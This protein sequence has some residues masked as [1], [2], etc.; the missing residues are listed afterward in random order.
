M[1]RF[2]S[3]VIFFFLLFCCFI[4][5]GTGLAGE[6]IR[7]GQYSCYDEKG[8]FIDHNGTGQD[9]DFQ[10]GRI[11]PLPR[12][13]DNGDGT[14]SDF[15]TGLMWLQDGACLGRLTWQGALE[16][17]GEESGEDTT[18]CAGY[19][20]YDDWTLPEIGQLENLFNAEENSPARW[21]NR[22]R[23]KNIRPEMYWSRTTGLNPY[24]AWVFDFGTGEVVN[25]SKVESRH[26]LLVRKPVAIG[27]KKDIES[28]KPLSL[29]RNISDLITFKSEMTGGD[30]SSVEIASQ[31][32]IR[33]I[34]NND[35]T[36]TDTATGLMWLRNAGCLGKT[37]WQ[38][39]F[40]RIDLLNRQPGE[41]LCSDLS[42]RYTDWALPNRNEFRSL[43]DHSTD[44]PALPA[45][46]FTDLRTYYWTSTTSAENPSKAYGIYLGSGE[47]RAA[48][49][50]EQRLIWA[51]RPVGGRV[52]RLRIE[53][54]QQDPLA[55]RDTRYLLQTIGA[56]VPIG[57]PAIRFTDNN[58]GTLTDNVTGLMW[59]MDA[60]CFQPEKR[61]HASVVVKWL[62][63]VPEKLKCEGYTA[64]YSDWFLPDVAT[65]EELVRESD[66]EPAAW[67]NSQGVVN[68]VPLDYWTEVENTWNLYHAWAF[69]M[70]QGAARNYPE[71]FELNVWPV[72]W[73][74]INESGSHEAFLRGNGKEDEILLKKG[75]ELLLS[76]AV[77]HR[78][79]T[80]PASFRIWYEAPDG[81][82]RWLSNRGEW[83]QDEA[84]AYRGN[85]FH[86]EES[87]FFRAD[88]TEL[89]PGVYAFFF[90]V[91]PVGAP[92]DVAA[93]APFGT[94]LALE[95]IGSD[96]VAAVDGEGIQESELE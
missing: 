86:L 20:A 18:K 69:N 5:G 16:L 47:L 87:V 78:G 80:A 76:A 45:N 71:S 92:G 21:L 61:K 37:I 96:D 94:T 53:E 33:F 95:L 17:V 75:D 90:S 56:N 6:P 88:T 52:E 42:A 93:F 63:T 39:A 83:L 31:V 66:G 35:G 2:C 8:A 73:P 64:S 58:D 3:F 24:S 13:Q 74:S 30:D 68:A 59:L 26:T 65:M 10:A 14:V 11:W 81:V 22:H 7:T 70:R 82:K 19:S 51:V 85:V 34:D 1:L 23:F 44:L 79:A 32:K 72:R 4:A 46:P 41:T 27:E 60:G 89:E 40:E 84:D 15:L 25:A 67:L 49:K 12:F 38:G 91:F 57:W 28:G 43:I 54:M 48:G 29:G 62:N 77:S 36:V 9:G 50:A 55:M